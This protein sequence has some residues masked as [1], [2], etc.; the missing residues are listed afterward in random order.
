MNENLTLE[1][2]TKRFVNHM[3]KLCPTI[4]IDKDIKC[5]KKYATLAAYSYFNSCESTGPEDDAEVDISYWKD[6]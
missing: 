3:I 1:E 5:L 4:E 2:Y 6:M